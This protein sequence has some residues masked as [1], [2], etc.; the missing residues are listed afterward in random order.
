[1][2][3]AI[4]LTSYEVGYLC[5]GAD[6]VAMVVL[7]GLH[8]DG[9]IRVSADRCRV[10]VVR[11]SSRDEV[12]KAALEVVPDV[13]R[14]FGL[15]TLMVAASAPVQ[16]V[17]RGLREKKLMPGSRLGRCGSGGGRR[18]HVTSG[19]GGPTRRRRTVWRGWR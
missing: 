4:E 17:G 11:R 18:G 13:G 16:E 6:R 10:H 1:M 7:A 19:A 9:R 12:E 2:V 15:T 5:G 3:D 8:A 14:V